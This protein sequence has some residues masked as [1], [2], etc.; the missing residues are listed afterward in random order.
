ML[1][2][3]LL[4]DYYNYPHIVAALHSP[5]TILVNT[6]ESLCIHT[7]LSNILIVEGDNILP[8]CNQIGLPQRENVQTTN[9]AIFH[10]FHKHYQNSYPCIQMTYEKTSVTDSNLSLLHQEDLPYVMETYSQDKYI[11]QLFDRKR[12]YGYYSNNK[13]LGYLAHHI[14]DSLGA[15]YVS[16][17]YRRQGYGRKILSAGIASIDSSILYSQVLPDNLASLALHN[18]IKCRQSDIPVFW[19][20]NTGFEYPE[21]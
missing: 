13:L 15:L 20:Y 1:L 9:A 14:D 21:N 11:Q 10:H 16:P 8:L 17:Q 18:S 3:K 7:T 5:H 6:V 2:D 12:L 19:M 4:A